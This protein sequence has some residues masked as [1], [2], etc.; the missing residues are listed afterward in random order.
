V[1]KNYYTKA[2]VADCRKRK[3]TSHVAQK[4]HTAIDGRTT[5]HAGYEISI[6]KLKQI[7]ECFGWMRLLF[8]RDADSQEKTQVGK[9]D[10]AVFLTTD[11]SLAPQRLLE[12]FV[13]LWQKVADAAKRFSDLIETTR[14]KYRINFIAEEMSADVLADFGVTT[15]AAKTFADRKKLAHRYVDLTCQER[16]TFGI[17]RCALHQTG[18]A[19]RLSKVLLLLWRRS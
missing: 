4:K 3:M 1:D 9:H 6:R 2:F 16:A 19:A 8:V 13:P 7:E 18:Q 17:D 15:T 5:R 14:K 10:W 12:L 11:I